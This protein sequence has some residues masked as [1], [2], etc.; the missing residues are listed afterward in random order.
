ML[1]TLAQR[2]GLHGAAAQQHGLGEAA[3]QGQDIRRIQRPLGTDPEQYR[4][5][6]V[7][8]SPPG[9]LSPDAEV[10]RRR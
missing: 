6:G 2:R 8:T 1:P 4:P 3:H 9:N 7:S 10:S 5:F